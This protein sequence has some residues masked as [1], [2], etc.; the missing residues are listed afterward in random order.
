MNKILSFTFALL[1]IGTTAFGQR[2]G[3]PDPAKMAERQTTELQEHFSGKDMA[4]DEDVLAQVE[5]LNLKYAEQAKSLR[6][7]NRGDREAMKEA[8]RG[9][10]EDKRKELKKLLSKDQFKEYKKWMEERRAQRQQRRDRQ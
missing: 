10:E 2:R 9:L 8:M 6:D 1:L 4:M 3:A 7:E 5:A